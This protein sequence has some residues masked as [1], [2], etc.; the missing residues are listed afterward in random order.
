MRYLIIFILAGSTLFAKLPE[1]F[2]YL[3][4]IDS[5]ILQDI[6]YYS[7]FNFVGK[8]VDGYKINKCIITE[9]AAKALHEVQ[10]ELLAYGFT[11]KVFD[12]YRPQKA[13]NHFYRWAKEV[14]DTLTRKFFYPDVDKRNLF[15]DGY[16]AEKSGHTRGST[17]DLTI[18]PLFV[19]KEES[20][21]V[22]FE[23]DILNFDDMS[24]DFGTKFD[25]F[26]SKSA[27]QNLE[28]N[29]KCMINRALLRTMMEKHGFKNYTLEWWHYT[30]INEPFPETYFDFDI[31]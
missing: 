13:V 22:K 29:Y 24:L 26:S 18:V 31:E 8:R 14:N 10:N 11:L 9:K 20:F 6:R 27:T 19:I 7:V 30:L 5:T 23:T 21:A 28:I 4:D 16:I 3:K 2:V 25:Y 12:A 1:G 15:K 17:V